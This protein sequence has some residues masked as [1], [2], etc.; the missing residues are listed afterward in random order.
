[1]SSYGIV[2]FLDFSSLCFV[3]IF[4]TLTLP[5]IHELQLKQMCF[6]RNFFSTLEMFILDDERDDEEKNDVANERTVKQNELTLCKGY[7]I[8]MNV[9]HDDEFNGE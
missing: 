7:K 8:Q 6:I 9:Q 5:K 1:M 4:S 3:F 2:F